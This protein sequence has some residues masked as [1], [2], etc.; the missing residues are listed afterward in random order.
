MANETIKAQVI[1]IVHRDP[2]LSIDEIAAQ[3]QTTPRYVRTILSEARLSLLH[4][5]KQYA[6]NMEQQ[7]RY[8]RDSVTSA[9]Y[10]PQLKLEKVKDPVIAEL[11]NQEPEQELIRISKMQYLNRVPAFCELTTYLELELRLA[12]I[13]GPLR[14][15][16]ANAKEVNN[17]Q[18]KQ[19]WVKV[20]ID[21]S[22]LSKIL[23]GRENQPLL[24]L[25]YLLY[26]DTKPVAV[27][28]QWFPIEGILLRNSE[29]S[30]EVTAD[31]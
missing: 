21:Q 26:N 15:V 31:V 11:L 29:G 5:R 25:S 3:V 19:S 16:L 8:T 23:I 13:S 7:L 30:I 4:L 12:D 2:F 27:E 24:K 22:N 14:N 20:V 10:E 28:T 18:L 1:D 6:K 17:L 9:E